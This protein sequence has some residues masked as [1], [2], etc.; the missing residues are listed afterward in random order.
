[1]TTGTGGKILKKLENQRGKEGNLPPLLEFYEK[2]LQVQSEIEKYIGIPGSGLSAEAIKDRIERGLPLLTFDELGLDW[3]LL[4]SISDRVAAVFAGYPELFGTVPD[5]LKNG[6]TV[7]FINKE[8]VRAWFEKS[9]LPDAVLAGNVNGRLLED[10]IQA[11]LRPLLASYSKTVLSHITQEEWRKGYCPVCGG[12]PDFAFLEKEYGARWL[13]C[14]RCDTEWLFQ[15]LECPYCGAV[16]QSALS[17]FTDDKGL[18]R[19]YVCERCK[20]Y[21]KTIDLR[22]AESDVLI[23]LERLLTLDIDAQAQENGYKPGSGAD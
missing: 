8:T 19:L 7:N 16:D 15:R 6:G 3:S 11:S 1:M 5:S 12:K 17:Y 4:P 14:S 13:V 2:L 20:C 22:Q 23:P 21:L 18:Y 9:E 10:I